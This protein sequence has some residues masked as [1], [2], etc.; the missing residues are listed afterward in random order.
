[1]PERQR[2][3]RNLLGDYYTSLCKHLCSDHKEL[4]QMEK[5]NRKTILVGICS[6][7]KGNFYGKMTGK[8]KM[9][10]TEFYEI[11]FIG[12]TFS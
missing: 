10:K 3:C 7:F 4:K 2:G 11:Q 8:N 5:Q 6:H 1:M 12:Q 9:G